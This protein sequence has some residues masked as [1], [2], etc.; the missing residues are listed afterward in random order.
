M[1]DEDA[2]DYNKILR[3][4]FNVWFKKFAQESLKNSNVSRKTGISL[5]QNKILGNYIAL[6]KEEENKYKNER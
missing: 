2:P 4:T 1:L 6:F 5:E 3:D